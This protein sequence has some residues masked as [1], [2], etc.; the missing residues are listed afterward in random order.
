MPLQKIKGG[1]HFG[2][3][4]GMSI[5]QNIT[6]HRDTNSWKPQAKIR[7]AFHFVER[8]NGL[9]LTSFLMFIQDVSA[10]VLSIH[11]LK[12][13]V[14]TR[15]LKT[16][17]QACTEGILRDFSWK[18][19]ARLMHMPETCKRLGWRCG[20]FQIVDPLEKT[21]LLRKVVRENYPHVQ[22][23]WHFQNPICGC[24]RGHG[25]RS[26]RHGRT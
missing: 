20:H 9:T 8:N 15:D 13:N 11:Q 14:S 18:R 24:F 21:R 25:R 12:N 19:S 5:F 6:L 26:R 3:L 2:F 10:G 4:T 22:Q 23:L 7:L 1:S 16:A 17:R